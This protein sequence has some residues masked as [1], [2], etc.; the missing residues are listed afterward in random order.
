M[1]MFYSDLQCFYV[2]SPP[3][4]APLHMC[5]AP[6]IRCLLPP[7]AVPVSLTVLIFLTVSSSYGWV[8][9]RISLSGVFFQFADFAVFVKLKLL[10]LPPSTLCSLEG[11]HHEMCP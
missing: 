7:L 11:S 5:S 2:M 1:S 10:P 4:T 9:N 3:G 8:L 6:E